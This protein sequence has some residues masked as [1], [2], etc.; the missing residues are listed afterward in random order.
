[1]ADVRQHRI[2][3]CGAGSIGMRHFKNLRTLEQKTL[4]VMEPD[5]ERRS[6]I[7][8]ELNIEAF[9]DLPT[10][11]RDFAPT[12]VFVCSPSKEH[13]AQALLAVQAGADVFIEKPLS[14]TIDDLA[15]LE[16]AAKGKIIMVG[17]N[18]RFHPGPQ[19]VK[20][21]L[22]A[23]AIG[24]VTHARVYAASYL[25]DWRPQSD[26]RKSYSADPV[27]GGAILDYIHEIDLTLWY[28]G[29]ATLK[30][31]TVRPAT[32]IKLTVD[33]E[34]DMIFAH[35]SGVTS[36]VSVSFVKKGY[37][38]GCV[39]TGENGRIVWEYGKGVRVEES[40]GTIRESFP[41]PANFDA[42]QM[43]LDEIRYF[44]ANVEARTVP[45]SSL[46]EGKAA[47]TIALAAK[48]LA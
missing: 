18:M 14:H 24:K 16:T 21:L 37:E 47:L 36:E 26:Y 39:I 34:A 9:G 1:M 7:T 23:G 12:V 27:Q 22:D 43:Y 35:T 40:D 17:C 15:E 48:Q 33:G 4:A 2:L 29:P 32:S 30:T 28:L 25:P 31:A 3:V 6:S 13:V 5:A 45:F 8:K 38:R 10:A 20:E 46:V 44:L 11:L 42:N 19:T 41:E